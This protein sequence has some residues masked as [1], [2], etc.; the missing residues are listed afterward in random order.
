M[1]EIR[2]KAVLQSRIIRLLLGE[3]IVTKFTTGSGW[4][5]ILY[6]SVDQAGFL[7]MISGSLFDAWCLLSALAMDSRPTMFWVFWLV[8]KLS[9]KSFLKTNSNLNELTFLSSS[10]I[11]QNYL[12]SLVNINPLNLV[13][14][15]NKPSI[16]GD[17]L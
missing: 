17:L 7:L 6:K 4:L 5:L 14:L 13:F 12:N 8:L 9:D 15:A 3:W 11:L 10:V 16:N 1:K 2:I